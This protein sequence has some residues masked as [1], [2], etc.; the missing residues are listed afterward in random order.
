[1]EEA[2]KMKCYEKVIYKQFVQISG[3]FWP[4]VSELFVETFH[5]PLYGDAIIIGGQ[6]LLLSTNMA[7]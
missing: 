7:A 6:K 4:T 3:L 5:A 2:K 1:M